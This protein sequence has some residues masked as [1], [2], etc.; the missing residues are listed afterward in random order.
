MK[1]I[2]IAY[3]GGG[4]KAW[5]RTFMSDLALSEGL[6]GEIGLYDIDLESAKRNQEIGQRINQNKKTKSFFEYVVY[7]ELK[8]CLIGATFVVI[9]ILPATFK[10]MESDVHAPEKYGIYQAVGD[11]VGPGGILRAMRTVPIYEDF[12]QQIKKHCPKAWV[13][14]FTNPMS[15]C[16]KVLY[17]VFPEIKAFGCCH[18]V[19]HAQNFL[20]LVLEKTLG[21]KATRKQITTDASGINHFTWISEAKYQDI[22]LL[23]LL[24]AFISKYYDQGYYEGGSRFQFRKDYF[25]YGNKV[26]MDL[27]N[28]Y[29]VLAAAGDRHLVEFMNSSWYLKN[30]KMVKY[31]KYRLT[32]VSYRIEDQKAKIADSILLAKGEKEYNLLPSGEEAVNLMKAILG[33]NSVISNV[34]LPNVGQM[35][36]LPLGSIVETNCQFSNDSLKPLVA[37]KLP[38]DVLNLIYQNCINIDTCYQGIKNRDFG[39]I[40]NAFIN[41]PL[42]A[43]LTYEEAE[44]LFKTM[45]KN[46]YDY[47]KPYYPDLDT[48]LADND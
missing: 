31:W 1:K 28:R 29:H 34:N 16:V 23:A 6:S 3:I 27:F 45:I 32:P 36:G 39:L 41:Q 25:A 44:T 33:F 22:D 8:D 38:Q 42:C 20:C 26:K 24:P 43:T 11:T 5:A 13:I 14:N 18:E 48:Y 35:S 7:L 15:I 10:E 17:D 19:F 37:K 2:K 9:S 47:L 30:P 4:S 12:A 21:I 46:T 40:F